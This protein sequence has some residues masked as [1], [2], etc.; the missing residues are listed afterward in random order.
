MIYKEYIKNNTEEFLLKLT[1]ISKKLKI[2]PDWLMVVM[3]AESK[4]NPSAVN[5][6]TNATGLIQF[7]PSTA[8]WLGTTTD[9]LK[10]MSNLEQLDFVLLYYQ[11]LGLTGKMKSVHDLYLGT[12]FPAALG[13]PDSWIIQT[14]S[15]S[16]EKIAEQNKIIDLNKD[17]KIT[18][19]EFKKYVDL[20]LKK[21]TLV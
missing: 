9:L 18:V 4:I 12:F 17:G 14:S 13:K 7:M 21:K 10:R 20:Y 15:I 16:A 3:Y 19:E 11:K 5:P 8:K 1:D 6:I 2:E